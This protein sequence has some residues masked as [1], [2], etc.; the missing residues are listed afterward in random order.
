MLY[1][2]AK[3]YMIKYAISKIMIKFL[4]DFEQERPASLGVLFRYYVS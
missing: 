4:N 1:S 2:N 3:V